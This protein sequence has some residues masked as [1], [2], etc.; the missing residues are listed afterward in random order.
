[1]TAPEVGRRPP[2]GR[3]LR[4]D[5]GQVA[6]IEAIPFGI[7]VFVVGV[8]LITNAWAVIDAKL[9]A[10]AASREAARAYVE[11]WPDPAASWADAQRRGRDAASAQGRD[12][13]RL[14]LTRTLDPAYERCGRVTITARYRVPA[15]SLPYIGG[16]GH[17]FTVGSTHSEVID[18]Y[19]SGGTAEGTCA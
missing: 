2:R 19:R 9:A 8:L 7:L 12:G 15:L 13:T 4:G 6:G 14:D 18:A 16:F 11:D 10:D 17:G 3:Q 1:V 5:A